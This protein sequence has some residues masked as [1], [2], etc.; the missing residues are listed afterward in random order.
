MRFPAV[1]LI[2]FLF[3]GFVLPSFAFSEGVTDQSNDT[4]LEMTLAEAIS[5]AL[6]TNR[7]VQMAYLDRTVQKF[8]LKVAED[9]FWPNVNLD[10]S[11][12]RTDADY[13]TVKGPGRTETDTRTDELSGA[14][15]VIETIPTGGT[16]QFIWN[17]AFNDYRNDGSQSGGDISRQR[18]DGYASTWNVSFT[19]PLLKGGGI[20][21]NTASVTQARL[22]EEAN[23]LSLKSTLINTVTSVINAYRAYIQARDQVEISKASLERA[24]NL[25]EINKLLIDSGR[26]AEVELVQSQ[27]EVASR[28]FSYEGVLNNF[29]R[30]RLALIKILDI[31]KETR[32]VL[33]DEGD[34]QRIEPDPDTCT[35]AAFENRPDYLQAL[36]GL[37]RSRINLVLAENNRLWDLSLNAAY[38]ES[39]SRTD[40]T[41]DGLDDPRL[42]NEGSE[43]R[44][45]LNLQI[46]L[47]GDLTRE[48]AILSAE[49]SLRKTKIGLK[50]LKDN[51]ETEVLDAIRDV[52]AKLKQVDLARLSR[53]LSEQKLMIEETKLKAGRST[54]FQL[55]SFQNDLVNAQN[56]ELN[57]ITDYRNALSALDQVLGTT[58]D[59]WQ[60]AFK[61]EQT[62]DQSTWAE[63]SGNVSGTPA[64][65]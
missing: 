61:S 41:V 36:L 11:V 59:T 38:G 30:A 56:A 39:D 5:L 33:A 14:V 55:V 16:F 26:M 50:E 64:K 10:G 51:V 60:I 31:P 25:V 2:A 18:S 34:V 22:N 12:S 29:D 20:D 57:A 32:F 49:A 37:E 43:W 9:K 46:P 15:S 19:Q 58:L 42:N 45:G 40:Q 7:S 23:I 8:D 4:V 44:V 35:R 28:E 63:S 27:A 21:V 54:N 47:W 65:P 24:R 52:L 53:K 48:Q 1:W 6:R 62:V 13:K 17:P 3:C